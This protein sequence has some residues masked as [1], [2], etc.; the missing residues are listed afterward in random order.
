MPRIRLFFI[1]TI[2]GRPAPVAI[3][4]WSKPKSHASSIVS[5]PPNRTPPYAPKPLSPRQHQLHHRQKILV[6]ADRDSV[7][8]NAAKS[9][10][11]A[12]VELLGDLVDVLDRFRTRFA[13]VAGPF[14]RE[15]VRS[16]G[17]RCR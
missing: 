2:V 14:V 15:A 12:F 6:P 7:F 16:S 17:R 13:V 8:R 10:Q 11:N 1:G 5:V 9:G 3:A 4:I